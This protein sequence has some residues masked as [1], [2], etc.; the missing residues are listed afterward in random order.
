MLMPTLRIYFDAKCKHSIEEIEEK[1]KVVPNRFAKFGN[2][3]QIKSSGFFRKTKI[4]QKIM[5]TDY[6]V[7]NYLLKESRKVPSKNSELFYFKLIDKADKNKKE[8]LD[9]AY[10]ILIK[11][12]FNPKRN[13]LCFY[14]R[15][16]L[17]NVT[18]NKILR[19]LESKFSFTFQFT[20]IDNHIKLKKNALD[21]FLASLGKISEF[22]A[23]SV[24]DEDNKIIAKNEETLTET[25]SILSYLQKLDRGDWDYVQLRKRELDFEIKLNNNKTLNFI[26]FISNFI[27]DKCL[28]RAVDYLLDKVQK[29]FQLEKKKQAN[30]TYY[31]EN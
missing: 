16:I 23:I 15:K 7:A 8:I 1:N 24:F 30:I 29:T 21:N 25:E 10:P 28:V 19:V 26:T 12:L 18:A 11:M 3:D 20:L 22:T 6:Y 13:Y 14:T 31:F 9:Y 2:D 17:K 27:D 5:G 4:F